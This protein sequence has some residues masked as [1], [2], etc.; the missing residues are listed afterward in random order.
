[1]HLT[2]DTTALVDEET[3]RPVAV[4]EI[5]PGDLL[6]IRPGERIPVDGEVAEGES[7]VDESMLTGED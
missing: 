5:E 2:P 4:A 6:R 7:H 3:E 1:M